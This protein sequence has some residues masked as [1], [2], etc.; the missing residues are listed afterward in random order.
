MFKLQQYVFAAVILLASWLLTELLT[1]YLVVVFGLEFRPGHP[2]RDPARHGQQMVSNRQRHHRERRAHRDK[3]LRAK[4][5][6]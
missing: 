2:F 1:R 6:E 5:P 4:T 3:A